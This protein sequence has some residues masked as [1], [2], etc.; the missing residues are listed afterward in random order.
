V[1]Y[2]HIVDPHTG[3]GLTN[4]AAATVIAP[5]GADADAL[6]SAACVLGPVEGIELIESIPGVECLV[7]T[8]RDGAPA[9]SSS[10]GFPR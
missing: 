5:S 6:A 2:S 9:T 3:L 7:S 8:S 4:R 10:T 1:R